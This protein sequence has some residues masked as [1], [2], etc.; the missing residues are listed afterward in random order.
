MHIY[1][2]SWGKVN[3][4]LISLCKSCWPPPLPRRVGWL[5]TNGVDTNGA[6]EQVMS[7][8]DWGKRYALALLGK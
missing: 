5:M 4:S 8:T 2:L 7:L 1:C 3:P 6:A